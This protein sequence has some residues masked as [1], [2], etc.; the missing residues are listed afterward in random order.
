MM[1]VA[2][3]IARGKPLCRMGE[4]AIVLRY[5]VLKCPVYL[6]CVNGEQEVANDVTEHRQTRTAQDAQDTPKDKINE[7]RK[8]KESRR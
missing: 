4:L 8:G 2:Q 3:W 7:Q 6:P 5:T 1:S